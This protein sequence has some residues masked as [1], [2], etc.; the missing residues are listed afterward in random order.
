VKR[1][2][3]QKPIAILVLVM[4]VPSLWGQQTSIEPQSPGGPRILQRYEP[5]VIPPARMGNSPRLADLIRGGTLYLTAQDAIALALENNIDLEVARYNPLIS[6]WQL[7]RSMSGGPL[8]GVPSGASQAGSVASGQG[9]AGSQ[10]A[11]GVSSGFSGAGG[12]QGSNATVSQVGPATQTL[13]PSFQASSVFSHSSSPQA[14]ATQSS[15]SNLISN[16]RIYTGTLKDGFLT[17]GNATLTYTDHYLNEN[18]PTDVL[19]PSV[20]PSLSLS[21]QHNLLNGFGIAVNARTI[22]VSKIGLETSELNFRNQVSSLTARVL[23]AYY[24]LAAD[25][26]NVKSTQTALDVSRAFEEF[27]R[28]Q[29]DNGAASDADLI[30]ARSQTALSEGS[31]ADALASVQDQELQLKSLLSRSGVSDPLLASTRIVTLDQIAL[32]E[33]DNLPAIPDLVQTAFAKRPDLAV[34]RANER[35]SEISSLGT[36]NGLRPTLQVLGGTSQA[37]LAG[38]PTSTRA[39]AYFVGGT[40]TALGQV[41]RRNFANENGGAVFV[42]Q[43]GNHQAQADFAID[44][45][46]LRQTQLANHKDLAQVE[47]DVMNWVIAIQQARA[48]S[49]AAV[50]N[51][52][53]QEDLLKGEQTKYELG[54]STPF[55]V[56]QQQRDLLSAQSQELSALVAYTSAR[57]NLDLTLG[58]ILDTNHVSIEEAKSGVVSRKSEPAR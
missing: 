57:I 14:N 12:G 50:H 28:K 27:V 9:V 25:Y 43:L 38:T 48:Q 32:P 42:T 19:N 3:F 31:A 26:V 13:D 49:E 18:A 23:G 29:I 8:P 22:N 15:V 47:V 37:G 34:D 44:Q 30:A 53:L 51:R 6:Q 54:T 21:F 58:T 40:G 55:A 56:T 20:A 46:Q 2:A 36:R 17:G 39:N 11:A 35:S 45:L 4:G 7:Q 33:K 41:I 52:I 1:G 10:S 24:S 5:R 16:T